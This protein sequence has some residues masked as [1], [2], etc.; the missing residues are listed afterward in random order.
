MCHTVCREIYI[1]LAIYQKNYDL[2][3]YYL[4]LSDEKT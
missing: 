3:K 1:D 4:H 2:P